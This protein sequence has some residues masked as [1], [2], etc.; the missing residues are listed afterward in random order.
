MKRKIII[1]VLLSA[2]L[3][4]AGAYT[5]AQP[6]REY[7]RDNKREKIH[8]K[9]NLTD[10]QQT[11]IEKLRFTHQ[12]T[13]IDLKAEVEKKELSLKEMQSEGNYSRSDYISKVEEL[14]A[15]QN[16]M[17]LANANHKMDVYELLDAEQQETWNKMK[18]M[19]EKRLDKKKKHFKMKNHF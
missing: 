15:A 4:L 2:I 18:P 16:K 1:S 3:I 17:K 19:R 8:E 13:M 9:L 11:Q 12:E 10:E 6:E 7:K 14:I 5:F